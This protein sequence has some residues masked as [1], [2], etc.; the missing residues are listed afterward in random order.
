[1]SAPAPRTVNTPPDSFALP[2]TPTLPMSIHV[3]GAGT[4]GTAAGSSA[5]TTL[6]GASPVLVAPP[7]T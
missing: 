3:H 4:V 2:S 7:G 1:M 5:S 6:V